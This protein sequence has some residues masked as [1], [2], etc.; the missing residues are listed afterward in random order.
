MQPTRKR[1]AQG[2]PLGTASDV[3]DALRLGSGALL[4]RRAALRLRPRAL[5]A[6]VLG[7]ELLG[8]LARLVVGP[9]VVRRLHEVRARAVDLA[10]EAVVQ[11]ELAAADG[12][13]D[14]AGRVGR[15]PDLE[16]HL[17]VERHVAEGLAL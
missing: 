10:A 1:P 7:D 5:L 8:R 11:R 3:A 16:L 13:D 4:R 9:L 12:V 15:V 6:L 2:G 17:H 14:D